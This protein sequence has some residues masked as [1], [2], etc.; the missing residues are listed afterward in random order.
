MQTFD[1]F[2]NGKVNWTALP[3]TFFSELLPL[4]DDLNELKITLFCF[5]ALQQKEGDFRYLIPADFSTDNDML[6]G[7]NEATREAAIAQAVQRGTLLQASVEL[8]EK[9]QTL[10]FLNTE[11]GRLAI[12]QIAAGKWQPDAATSKIEI[13]PERPNIY[14]LYEQ[15]I[16]VLTPHIADCLKDAKKEYTTQW[17]HDAIVEAVEKNKRSWK[18]I[19]WLLNYWDQNGKGYETSKRSDEQDGKE[20]ATGKYSKFIKS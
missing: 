11:R 18:Y 8:Q 15:N 2:P 7:L 14:R 20:Y 3:T 17:V 6:V 9:A 12:H 16:G 19:N 1:G 10:Y 4:I 5:W 13:L